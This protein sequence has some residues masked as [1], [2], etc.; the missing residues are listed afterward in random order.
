MIQFDSVLSLRKITEYSELLKIKDMWDNLLA[1]SG[2][3]NPYLKHDWFR[4]AYKHFENKAKLFILLVSSKDKVIAIAPFLISREKYNGICMKRIRFLENVHTPFQDI[5]VTQ[6]KQESLKTIVDFLY[7]NIQMWDFMELK[8]I[9]DDSENLKI[10][11]SLCSG[12]NIFNYQFFMTSSWCSPTN[13]SLKEGLA[14]LKPKVRR[15]QK[16]KIRRIER[17]GKLSFQIFTKSE[18]IEKHLDIFFEIYKKTWKGKEQNAGFYYQIAREFSKRNEF[19]IYCL[20]LNER[21]IAYTCCLKLENTLFCLK[22]TFDASYYAFSPGSIMFNKILESAYENKDIERFDIGRGDERYKQD[23][24][25]YPINHIN[26][27]GGHKKTFVSYLLHIRFK[28]VIYFKKKKLLNTILTFFKDTHK[29]MKKI[30]E[31]Y[32]KIPKIFRENR[33]IIVFHKDLF[34]V[35]NN[36]NDYFYRKA[37]LDDIEHLAVAMKVK[38]LSNLKEKIS[39]EYC[40]IIQKDGKIQKYFWFAE[41]N[42][43]ANILNK[44]TNEIILTDFDPS[45]FNLD[46]KSLN[47]LFNPICNELVKQEYNGLYAFSE[48]IDTQKNSFYKTLGFKKINIIKKLKDLN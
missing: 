23:M 34:P 6:R 44:N 24:G 4:I 41:N 43:E 28:L 1:E 3:N 18:E 17:Q 32:A 14:K 30:P 46:G 31:Y 10:L 47:N 38:K 33:R 11:A 21:P 39:T 29:L 27:I 12:V 48:S 19:I 40:Y 42:L 15:E 36:N 8:E 22:T 9:R 25:T 13:M 20:S 35:K 7:N 16:R 26:F 37:N 5:I 2:I 45:L